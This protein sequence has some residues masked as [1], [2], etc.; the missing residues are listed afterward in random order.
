MQTL[1]I[2]YYIRKVIAQPIDLC[3][4]DTTSNLVEDP[5]M[6]RP[7]R[8]YYIR[9]WLAEFST[10]F[11]KIFLGED[12]QIPLPY[13]IPHLIIFWRLQTYW[14]IC[15]EHHILLGWRHRKYIKDTI[16]DPDGLNSVP[17]FLK[18]SWGRTPR[19][20]SHAHLLLL[21]Y[22]EGCRPIDIFAQNTIF[23]WVE[24]IEN[25]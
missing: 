6:E 25:I 4:Q 13:T 15:P 8:E 10:L 3:S 23:Y 7:F 18:F 22:S 2:S 24:D 19:P 1:S 21:S 20:P 14:Y 9:P 17:F 16:Y 5:R 12:P 11:S